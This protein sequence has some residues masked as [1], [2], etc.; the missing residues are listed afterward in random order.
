MP[1]KTA[2]VLSLARPLIDIDFLS[3]PVPDTLYTFSSNIHLNLSSFWLIFVTVKPSLVK[4]DISVKS[5]KFSKALK[6]IAP[7]LDF[8]DFVS[9]SN[10]VSIIF[11]FSSNS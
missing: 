9:L 11:P 1:N 10:S 7:L 6:E 3:V 5:N 8:N 2:R 4:L